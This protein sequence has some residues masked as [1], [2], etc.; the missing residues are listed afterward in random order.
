[1]SPLDLLWLYFILT[2]LQPLIEQR[3][4]AG[5]RRWALQALE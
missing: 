2:S 4:L 5:R 1:M 3:V